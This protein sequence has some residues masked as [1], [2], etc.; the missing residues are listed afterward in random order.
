MIYDDEAKLCGPIEVIE[1]G[2]YQSRF[3]VSRLL[4]S[5]WPNFDSALSYVALLKT[6]CNL[7]LSLG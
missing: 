7:E 1:I 6:F 4:D 2:L 5:V 3:V